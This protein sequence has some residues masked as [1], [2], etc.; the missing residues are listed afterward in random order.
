MAYF[1]NV[2]N[3]DASNILRV[4]AGDYFFGSL[5]YD[6]FKGQKSADYINAND[7]YDAMSVGSAELFEGPS[8]FV[9]YA[10][11]VKPPFVLSN[12]DFSQDSALM[13]C[14]KAQNVLERGAS[15]LTLWWK[16]E[17]KRLAS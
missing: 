14:R 7:L 8:T 12:Y 9:T 15:S 1:R 11:D 4:D 16:R 10:D 13:T 6:Q 5:W 3:S 2:T 17:R